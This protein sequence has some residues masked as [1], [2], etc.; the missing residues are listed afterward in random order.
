MPVFVILAHS[1]P[2]LARRLVYALAPYPVVIHVDSK[3]DIG[4]FGS[5]PR[6][7]YVQDREK[8]HWGGLSVVK[9][10]IKLF[11]YALEIAEPDDHI[12]LL[13]GQC[14]PAAPPSDFAAYL[15]SAPYK[16]HC[17]AAEV[18][19]GSYYSERRLSC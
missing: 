10:T 17:D 1:Q 12:V 16:Q 2:E 18:F 8:V 4:E 6:T 11:E 19:D 9:A 7:T 5:L 13:S 15:L 3:A 14:Y